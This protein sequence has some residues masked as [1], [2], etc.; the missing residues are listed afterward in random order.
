MNYIL[1]TEQ[2]KK[3]M[4]R[5]IGLKDIDDLFKG[6][7]PKLNRE[8]KLPKPMTEME[9]KQL[10]TRLAEK[11]CVLKPFRGA[12]SYTHYV[13]SVVN[14]ILLRGEFYTAYTPYQPEVSQGTLQAIYEFQTFLCQLTEMDVANASMYDGATALA[15]AMLL[16]RAV[17]GR[18]EVFVANTTNPLYE[19]VLKTYADATDLKLTKE[20]SENTACVIVQYPDYYGNIEQ[21]EQYAKQAHD[22]GALFVVLITDPTSLAILK[23]PGAYSA[24]VVVGDLQALGNGVN[25]GGPTGGFMTIKK[26]YVKKLPGRL[27]GLT[28]DSRGEE[29]FILTLQAREQ[30]IRREKATSN[31]CTNQALN[32]LAST[33]YLA[34]LG[35]SGLQRVAKLSYARAH[36]LQKKLEEL[37]FKLVNDKPFYNEFTVKSPASIAKLN[38]ALENAGFLGG[39]ELPNQHWLLCCTEMNSEEDIEQ[40]V[41]IVK[42]AVK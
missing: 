19:K 38:E 35:K 41:K 22:K 30:H 42:E 14:H 3:E 17:N 18:N 12:G 11:N 39:S 7:E 40:F 33:V 37:G 2:D 1:L 24:D 36:T 13:P 16:S 6:V 32:A 23:P 8:L 31:I 29:G 34:L 28:K 5:T 26:D 20:I 25:Y 27:S 9:V 21:L 15:E 10:V 4:L